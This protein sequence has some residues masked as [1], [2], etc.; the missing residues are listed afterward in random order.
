MATARYLRGFVNYNSQMIMYTESMPVVTFVNQKGGTGKTTCT[1]NLAS[2]LAAY[3]KRVLVVDMDPQS[4]ATSTL[5]GPNNAPINIYHTLV[6]G[7]LPEDVIRPSGLF[8]LDILPASTDLAGASIELVNSENREFRLYDTVSR[9]KDGYDFVLIDCPPS[10]GLLTLNG[11][12]AAD[13]VIIPVQCEYYALEGLS[14]LL[15]TVD[16]IRTNLDKDV[17]VLGAVAT[18]YDKRNRLSRAVLKEVRRNFP[19]YVFDT[20]IPRSISLAEAP[21]HSKTI[22]QFNPDSVGAS[23]YRALAEEFIERVNSFN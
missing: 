3:G 7:I 20:V 11:I 23:A 15:H 8:S 4:N 14:Q 9:L 12:V 1:V 5:I 17:K 13:Y 6:G 2:Y 22:Y 19:G 10:L 18:M 21:G 16:L